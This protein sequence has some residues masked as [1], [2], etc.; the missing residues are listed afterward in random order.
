MVPCH[1]YLF[2]YDIKQEQKNVIS[3]A[4]LFPRDILHCGIYLSF[5]SRNKNITWNKCSLPWIKIF[6]SWSRLCTNLR[7]KRVVL[8]K[9]FP[10]LPESCVSFT[11]CFFIIFEFQKNVLSQP[12]FSCGEFFSETINNMDNY[13]AKGVKWKWSKQKLAHCTA[14]PLVLIKIEKAVLGSSSADGPNW[15]F[16]S[17]SHHLPG[18]LAARI[19]HS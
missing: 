8:N 13:N 4:E 3:F 7:E 16:S 15:S 19:W 1:P 18:I 5:S 2:L 17:H 11:G 14:F 12:A 10:G 6:V 9:L